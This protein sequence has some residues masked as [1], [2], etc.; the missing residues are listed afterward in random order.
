MKSVTVSA[1]R[2]RSSKNV[3][4]TFV[5][6]TYCWWETYRSS[7]TTWWNPPEERS[8]SRAK[9]LGLSNRGRQAQSIDPWRETSAPVCS[10]PIRP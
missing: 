8:S 4:S 5:P 7:G 6:V 3:A 9:T 2:R 1:T 10:F